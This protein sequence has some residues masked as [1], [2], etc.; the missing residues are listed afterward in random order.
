MVHW[1]IIGLGDVCAVKS[2]QA[3]YK[4]NGSTL[5]AVMRRT[6]NAAQ[7]WIQNNANNLPNDVAQSIRAFDNIESIIHEMMTSS[8]GS[9]SVGLLD[10]IYVSSPPGAH[11]DNIKQIYQSSRW[12]RKLHKKL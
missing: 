7:Q 6:P 10:A 8:N 11:L 4:C 3:F 12:R 9:G 2:G 5:S 1:A